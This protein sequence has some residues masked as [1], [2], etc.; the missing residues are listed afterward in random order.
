MWVRASEG[1]GARILRAGAQKAGQGLEKE[2]T[3]A[4]RELV[5]W[6]RREGASAWGLNDVTVKNDRNQRGRG[7]VG[8]DTV[9]PGVQK[10]RISEVGVE[11]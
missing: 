1:Q 8:K 5:A 2:A 4:R 7:P 3:E 9:V 10:C 6:G 11:D